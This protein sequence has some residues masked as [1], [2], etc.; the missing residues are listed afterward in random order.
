MHSLL[1]LLILSNLINAMPFIVYSNDDTNGDSNGDDN[2]IN[3]YSI[4][5]YEVQNYYTTGII[6]NHN[7]LYSRNITNTT[8]LENKVNIKIYNRKNNSMK[9]EKNITF[10][11][12]VQLGYKTLPHC[13]YTCDMLVITNQKDSDYIITHFHKY[14][15]IGGILHMMC[16]N[17]MCT[18]GKFICDVNNVRDEL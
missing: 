5:C 9:T 16:N 7:V 10:Y 8:T 15:R 4:P 6:V 3:D 17:T 12:V 18:W 2:D 13:S 1:L 14:F 11:G